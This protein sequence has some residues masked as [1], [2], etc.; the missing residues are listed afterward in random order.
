M[1]RH[2]DDGSGAGVGEEL[3][4]RQSVAQ[5]CCRNYADADTTTAHFSEPCEA[6]GAAA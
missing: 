4:R 5:S 2:E 1:L 3:I 6:L